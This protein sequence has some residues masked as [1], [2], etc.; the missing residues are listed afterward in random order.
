MTPQKKPETQIPLFFKDT[1][2]IS[3]K[4]LSPVRDLCEA[5][6]SVGDRGA[7]VGAHDHG[8]S[9]VY[10]DVSGDQAD[11]DGGGGRG[12]LN[13]HRHQHSDHHSHHRVVQE[14]RVREECWI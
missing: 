14:G 5:D 1:L 11:D 4:H 12:G 3:N 7:D 13:Q 2:Y 10:R 8:Y 9:R 6:D